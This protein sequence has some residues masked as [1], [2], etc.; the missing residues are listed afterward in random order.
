MCNGI[1][2][3]S[4]QMKKQVMAKAEAVIDAWVVRDTDNTLRALIG[5]PIWDTFMMRWSYPISIGDLPLPEELYPDLTWK[6]EPM[7]VKLTITPVKK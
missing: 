2:Q 4:Q 7:H 5:K 3:R 6:S 1:T